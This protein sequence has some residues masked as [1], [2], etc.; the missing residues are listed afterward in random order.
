MTEYEIFLPRTLNNEYSIIL[1]L[2]QKIENNLPFIE[3]KDSVIF[4]D[5]FF[6][7]DI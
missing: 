5:R 6:R 2:Y 7:D 1:E 4:N 3:E